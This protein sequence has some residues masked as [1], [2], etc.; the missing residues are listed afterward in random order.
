MST[1]VI[2]ALACAVVAIVYGFV[3]IGWIM[4]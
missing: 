4:N 2:F 3:S 1:S